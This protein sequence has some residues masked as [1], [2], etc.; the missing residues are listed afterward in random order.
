MENASRA[1]HTATIQ[2]SPKRGSLRVQSRRRSSPN[3]R[4]LLC[5][6]AR[7]PT[8][9]H[10]TCQQPLRPLSPTSSR[11]AVLL[12]AERMQ[13]HETLSQAHTRVTTTLTALRCTRDN[14]FS[15]RVNVLISPSQ[16]DAQ[17]RIATTAPVTTGIV[18]P[19]GVGAIA[20]RR[21]R[22]RL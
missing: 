2:T 22:S 5:P 4:S 1:L 20:R 12:H 11:K 6:L 21:R 13:V 17:T 7:E 10:G 14:V 16:T 3:V 18:R 19:T 8:A 15:A 9:P